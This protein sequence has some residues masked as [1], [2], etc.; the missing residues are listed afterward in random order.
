MAAVQV[1]APQ[2]YTRSKQHECFAG[3][4]RKLGIGNICTTMTYQHSL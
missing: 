2:V 1:S 4:Q 3:Q